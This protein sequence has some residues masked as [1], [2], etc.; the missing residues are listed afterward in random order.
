MSLLSQFKQHIYVINL[1]RRP[2]RWNEVQIEMA[3]AGITEYKRFNGIDGQTMDLASMGRVIPVDPRYHTKEI[4]GHIGCSLSHR[5]VLQDAILNNA[6]MYAVIED[7]IAFV[8]NF[9]TV[10]DE[11]MA[12]VPKDWDCIMLGGSHVSRTERITTRVI[13]T[14]GSYTTHGLLIN[15]SFY[16]KLLAIWEFSL[17][18]DVAISSLHATNNV[19]AFN[20][21]LAW[22]RAGYSD[23]LCKHDDYKHLR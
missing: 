9:D 3:R 6:D 7:D 17:E 16:E 22:Q 4:L 12:D 1:E 14:W 11:C 15:K 10:F 13:K 19:Y 8:E 23:I 5:G 18:V 20:P 2:D 21:P